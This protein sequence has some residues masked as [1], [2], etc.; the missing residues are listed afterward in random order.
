ME[1]SFKPRH[2]VRYREVASLLVR[3]GLPVW[4]AGNG[5][6]DAALT[7][8]ETA[9]LDEAGEKLA[10]SLESMGPTFVKLGQMLSTRADLLPAP[11]LAALARLQDK[12]EPFGFAEVEKLVSTELGVRLSDGFQSFDHE[13]LAAASLGQVHRATL[14]D[15]R[16]VVVKV[17]R[18]N[19]RAQ[20]LDDMEVISELAAFVDERTQTGRDI[21]FAPMVEEF[22]RS[23][24]GE[25][26]Y[27]RE[28]S[29]LTLLSTQLTDHPHLLVP[30]PIADYTTSLV[31]TMD[32]VA[33]R[34]VGAL[35]P[36]AQLDIDGVALTEELF[37]A[38]L[39]HILVDGFFHAD[40]HPGNI[41]LTDDGR[42]A[43]I[44]LGMVARV[45]PPL[46]DALI[47]LLVAIGEGRGDQAAEV[48]AGL[49]EPQPG[50][51]AAAFRNRTV[52]LLDEYRS[53][54]LADIQAGRLVGELARIS[55]AAGLR[56][57][58]ELTMVSKALLNLDE[59]AR[60]LA[61][62]FD[63]S[64]EI[65][66][67]L[68][69][70]L[71]RK[72]AASASPGNLLH[73]ALDAKEFAEKLPSRVNKVMDALA[74][75][76]LTLNVQ[77][78]DEAELMRGIQKLANRVTAG[79]VVAALVLGAGLFGGVHSGRTTF[80][81]PTLSVVLLALAGLVGAWLVT[82]ALRHDLPQAAKRPKR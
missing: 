12:C 26:D 29:N 59:V 33:G 66:G 37:D 8:E 1:L 20:I 11:Y 56:P 45:T 61:P 60:R 17:Q 5:G 21:G 57:P 15:G 42:L 19:I 80:G 70:I 10:A 46:Q 4:R 25:L 62:T 13:P 24:L 7:A 53:A 28:A 44:D 81:Y 36:L 6:D 52:A 72:M 43:L 78:I 48:L 79:L 35:G 82:S 22:R 58:P 51:D 67:H 14:R 3:H 74:E 34:N 27:K 76:Q 23:L 71:R 31:L 54:S 49:G 77:G 47:R 68:Q 41:L 64:E 69:S 38:Y 16:D 9:D 50:Y 18:P 32:H 73:A 75:G 65:R 39:D 55:G 40:P 30:C 63:P 2:L